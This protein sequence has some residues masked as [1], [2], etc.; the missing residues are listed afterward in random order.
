[1]CKFVN[2]RY[3]DIDLK[4]SFLLILTSEIIEDFVFPKPN[5]KQKRN[6]KAPKQRRK[7]LKKGKK[8]MHDFNNALKSEYPEI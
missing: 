7:T 6:K 5:N 8:Y 2:H 3:S 1:M 4:F